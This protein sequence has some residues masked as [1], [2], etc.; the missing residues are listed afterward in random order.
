MRG[1]FVNDSSPFWE[2]LGSHFLHLSFSETQL[3]SQEGK[4]FI[5]EFLPPFPIYV[6]MLS[7]EAQAVIDKTHLNTLPALQILLGEGF[8]ITN[9]IDVFDGGPKVMAKTSEVRT[10]KNC[11]HG[12][13][14]EIIPKDSLQDG[15]KV[16]FEATSQEWLIANTLPGEHFRVCQH[17]L[18]DLGH[19]QVALSAEVAKALFLQVGDALTYVSKE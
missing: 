9:D 16:G 13:L 17:K 4:D 19:R 11:R 15:V 14:R 5:T 1:I 6:D 2:A 7:K 12:V 3:I 8:A 10:I 18:R